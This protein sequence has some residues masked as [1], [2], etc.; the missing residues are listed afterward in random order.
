MTRTVLTGVSGTNPL[1]FLASVGLLRIVTERAQGARLGFLD[2]GSFQ[3]F[4][5]GVDGPLETLVAEDAKRSAG[6]QAWRL[7]Y[8]KTTKRGTAPVADLK[9]PPDAFERFL[10]QRV[11]EWIDGNEEGATYAAC[12]ATSV[13]RDG[14]GNT[15]PTAF[16][17]TAANQQFLGAVETIRASVTLDWAKQSLFE[18]GAWRPGGN[19]RWDPA[20]DRNYALMANDPNDDGT[21]VDAPLEWLAFR[22]LPLFPT[23]P[24]GMRV[25]TTGV[26]GRGD[27]MAFTWPLWSLGA[28]LATVEA[29]V[30]CSMTDRNEPELSSRGVFAIASS[31]IRRTTQGFGNF[32]PASVRR[33]RNR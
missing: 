15:K 19:L 5:D 1:G 3:P 7:E 17:F 29:L 24:R 2:D 8:G 21:S 23:V 12:Y 30:G 10:R 26:T 11:A 22:G 18:G 32:G 25:L 4:L 6:N 33:V 16:H 27:E 28:R 14:K 13:A 31:E 9:P 20:A